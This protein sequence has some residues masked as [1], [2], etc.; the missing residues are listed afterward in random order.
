MHIQL[1]SHVRLCDPMNCSQPDSSIY[2]I[3]QVRSRL[4]FPSRKEG[5]NKKILEL[6]KT[7]ADC[8]VGVEML[9]LPQGIFPIQGLNRCLLHFLH[10]QANSLPLCHL[11]TPVLDQKILRIKTRTKIAHH[12]KHK[13][14]QQSC[15]ERAN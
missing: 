14:L 6:N 9:F 2:G 10:W 5:E 8:F 4:P 11:G 15:R 7:K 1:L 13:N 12:H 3:F